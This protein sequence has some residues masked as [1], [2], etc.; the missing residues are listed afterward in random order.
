MT[1]IR[2]I[3]KG[4]R[5]RHQVRF[6]IWRDGSTCRFCQCALNRTIDDPRQLTL[7]HW[8]PKS[9]GGSNRVR[10]LVLACATCNR[11]KGDKPAEV[12]L[13]S[14]QLAGRVLAIEREAQC[15]NVETTTT[16]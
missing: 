5:K 6:L 15:A 16:R 1:P 4:M 12:Y 8:V 13:T 14:V 7:D 10:N 9:Q 2:Y 3:L 11:R